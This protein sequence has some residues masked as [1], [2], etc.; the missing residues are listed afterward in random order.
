MSAEWRPADFI[1]E[2]FPGQFRNWFYAL[3]ALSTMMSDGEAPFKTLLGHG[4]V[5]D[6]QGKE[7]HKSAGNSIEF[8]SAAEE[9]GA[10]AMRWLYCRA[11]PVSNLNFGPGPVSEVRGK[12][13][14]KL[15]NCYAFFANYARLDG[16]D[17]NASQVPVKDRPDIDRWILSDL[18]GLI[19]TARE[20]FEKYDVMSFCLETERFVDDRFSNWYV[21]HNRDRFW[22]KNSELD[23]AGKQDK[24]SAYQTMYEVL[25]TLC[26][27]IA[28]V[29]P[30]LSEV[31]WKNLK[32]QALSSLDFPE[33]VHLCEYPTPEYN[34]EIDEPLE[35]RELLNAMN[36]FMRI[37]NYTLS[38]RSLSKQKVRQ[39]LATLI[40]QPGN[41]GE[42]WALDRF[43][44]QIKDKVNV[45]SIVVQSRD[46]DEQNLLFYTFKPNQKKLR[47][48]DKDHAHDLFV[49][50]QTGEHTL[51]SKPSGIHSGIYIDLPDG[52]YNLPLDTVYEWTTPP[53]YEGWAFSSVPPANST[54]LLLDTRITPEL[55]A[56]GLARDL[57]RFIQDARKDAGLDVADKIALFLGTESEVLK[58][59]I[60][61]HRATI[62]A[63]AQVAEWLAAPPANGHNATVKVDGQSV[64]I[65]VRKV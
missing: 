54:Q 23:E 37:V 46:S 16:F 3:L 29:V 22:S 47:E 40:I 25:L 4:L 55:K 45:K 52:R 49:K 53:G 21:N 42:K 1:T 14:L 63:D 28:P 38:L 62:I 57:V 27:L 35:T 18:Q 64:T 19:R 24:L 30:F 43:L 51:A 2:S 26:K 12:F 34:S 9:L 39:P 56:E 41:T 36:G 6:E 33:S 5:R 48:W 7:M 58:Q 20:S 65:G 61:A 17:P 32:V 11:N 8:N 50:L 59:A 44:T 60:E 15:W 13:I 10:D 31:I